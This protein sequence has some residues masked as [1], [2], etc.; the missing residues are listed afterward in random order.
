MDATLATDDTML[1]YHAQRRMHTRG[2]S[3]DA[4]AAA[5]TFGRRIRTRGAEVHVIGRKEVKQY[6]QYG[7]DLSPFA[8]VQIICA[9]DGAILTVYRN[10]NFR[11]LRP[12]TRLRRRIR[13][14]RAS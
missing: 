3:H 5:L 1:T 11:Q 4:V 9:S 7:I 13:V 10:Q 8:G 6:L 2:L 12:R 14:V